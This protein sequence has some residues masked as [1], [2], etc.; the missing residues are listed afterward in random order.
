MESACMTMPRTFCSGDKLD[1][2]VTEEVEKC[3]EEGPEDCTGTTTYVNKIVTFNKCN[4]AFNKVC[5]KVPKR[6][7]STKIKT[8]CPE[9]KVVKS[10]HCV[11]VPKTVCKKVQKTVDK[12]VPRTVC[13][14]V[15]E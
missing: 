8:V 15:C 1:N 7:C 14:E 12:I 2:C 11:D 5:K 3:T 6:E 9:C 4:V 13:D 10:Q